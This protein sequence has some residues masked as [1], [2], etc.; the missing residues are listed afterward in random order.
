MERDVVG[1]AACTVEQADRGSL[2]ARQHR[3]GR[4]R[5]L[6]AAIREEP[7]A[8]SQIQDTH[9]EAEAG[10]RRGGAAGVHLLETVRAEQRCL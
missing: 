10:V 4:L 8:V 7:R 5:S 9:A 3:Q 6:V 2:L 1:L